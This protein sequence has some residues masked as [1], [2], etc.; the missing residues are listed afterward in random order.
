MGPSD[1]N[2]LVPD[3]NGMFCPVPGYIGIESGWT[4]IKRDGI[5]G[6]THIPISK[7]IFFEPGPEQ[8][9]V[10]SIPVYQYQIMILFHSE[11]RFNVSHSVPNNIGMVPE[12]YRYN[13]VRCPVLG[14]K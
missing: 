5:N 10:E 12:W 7:N 13:P 2:D 1:Q 8:N 3:R 6:T 9:H 4:E 14:T 11:Y